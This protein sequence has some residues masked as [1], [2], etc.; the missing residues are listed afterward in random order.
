M[1]SLEIIFGPM[2]SG[3]TELLIKKYNELYNKFWYQYALKTEL[4]GFCNE[5][6][7]EI[8]NSRIAINYFMDTR[9]KNNAI[10]SHDKNSIPSLNLETLSILFTENYKNLLEKSKYIFINEAQF[11]PDLKDSIVKLL[12]IYNKNIVIC[13]LDSDF[14]REKFGEM[15][16]L[17]PHANS[18][19]KLTGKCHYCTNKS[20][21]S[22]RVTEETDQAVIG[23]T[24][25]LPL[26]RQ[27]YFTKNR[28]II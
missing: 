4:T 28:L 22:Y 11:F 17:I 9:Y 1:G 21:F 16:D 19:V 7:D 13:G 10:V 14:K 6:F 18:V 23:T 8:C 20:L 12:E 2:F 5:Q 25:Y 27:C 15:W 3:K 24:N 26:C